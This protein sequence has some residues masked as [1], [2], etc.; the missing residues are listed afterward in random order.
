MQWSSSLDGSLGS[1]AEFPVA[2][3]SLG[4]HT[5]TVTATDGQGASASAS[6]QVTV[7]PDDDLP[8]WQV[9]APLMLRTR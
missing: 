1:G 2:G 9:F 4:V 7:L 8:P 5:I 6:V 3:L